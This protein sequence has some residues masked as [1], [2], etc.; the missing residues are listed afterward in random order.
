VNL[1]VIHDTDAGQI[2]VYVNDQ[3]AGTWPDQGGS[4]H[5]SRM[6]F[7]APPAAPRRAGAT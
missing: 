1:K 7:M 3:P 5:T 4:S 2:R 6:A